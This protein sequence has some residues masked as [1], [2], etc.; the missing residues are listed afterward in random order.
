MRI[1]KLLCLL[2]I[3]SSC[4]KYLGVVD[5]DYIPTEELDDIFANDIDRSNQTE[6]LE[7]KKIIYPSDNFQVGDISSIKIKKIISL[8]ESSA[9][10]FEKDKIY[11]TKQG[12]LIIFDLSESKEILKIDLDI[13]KEEKIIKI[14]DYSSKKFILS[15][16]SKLFLLEDSKATLIANFDKF[17]NDQTILNDEKLLIFTV[18]GDL[19]EINLIKYTSDFKG[20]FP[21]NHGVNIKSENY[22]YKNQ[23]SHLFNSGTLIFLSQSDYN[24]ETNYFL[25]DLNILSSFGYF[26]EFIDAPFSHNNYLY[27][28]ERSGL[29]AV[30]NPL[31]SEFLW[32]TEIISSI[33]DFNFS[34]DGNL[35]LLTNKQVLIIDNFGNLITV[36]EH[37]N[38]APLKL[39]SEKDK[40]L[41]IDE[42]GI[43]ILD[44]KSGSRINFLK[45]KFDGVVEYIHFNSNSYIRDSKELYKLSE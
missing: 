36:L 37:T 7:I 8:D 20:K 24:L 41:I 35:L 44:L 38:E 14:F 17:I 18:F 9:I 32:E 5:K 3:L 39:I 11:F 29:I 19:Y 22:I 13:D 21:T 31:E 23:I 43:D 30:F 10:Y 12:D 26:E 40:I 4:N 16:K 1:I 33:K 42:K 15:N 28:I 34:E 2:F 25:E 45:N 27:F 6:I